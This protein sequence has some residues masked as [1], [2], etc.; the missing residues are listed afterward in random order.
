MSAASAVQKIVCIVITVTQK[1]GSMFGILDFALDYFY[2]YMIAGIEF[3]ITDSWASQLKIK[4]N[5]NKID[6]LVM[7]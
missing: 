7:E 4:F 2:Q 6:W 3:I 5:V 1:I